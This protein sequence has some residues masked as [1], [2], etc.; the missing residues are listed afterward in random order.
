MTGELA[1]YDKPSAW[2]LIFGED[3]RVYVVLG[4]QVVGP[5]PR[6]SQKVLFEPAVTDRGLRA[7]GVRALQ[8]AAG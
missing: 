7:L 4:S 2:G 3:G 5:P 6:V 1:F 8:T